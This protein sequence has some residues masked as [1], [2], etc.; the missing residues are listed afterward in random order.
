MRFEW[1][2]D[3][4]LVALALFLLVVFTVKPSLAGKVRKVIFRLYSN[5]EAR[6]RP[7]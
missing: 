4:R 1:H 7:A 3:W 6:K 2:I 5:P